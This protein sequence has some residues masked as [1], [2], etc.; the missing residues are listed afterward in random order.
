[1]LL[2]PTQVL[3]IEDNLADADLA[4][5]CLESGKL[6]LELSVVN[7]GALALDFLFR[8][9]SYGAANRPDLIILDL[10]LPRKDGRQVLTEIKQDAEL[11]RIPV[12]VLTSSEAEGDILRSYDLGAN[13]YITKPLDLKAFQTI[14]KSIEQFWF[15][16]AKLPPTDDNA[17]L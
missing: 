1:M 10:N 9:G 2:K 4:R 16:I 8:R 6:Y 11:K 3:L 12:V 7:D 17:S 14:V 5:E 15:T 13:C